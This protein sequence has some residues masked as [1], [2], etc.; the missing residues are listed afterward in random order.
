MSTDA[1]VIVIGAGPG[2]LSCA[3]YLA[4]VGKR[5]I[6]LDRHTVPGGNMSCFTHRDPATDD[7]YEFDVGLHYLGSCG[8]RGTMPSVLEPLG[9]RPDY[10]P[11]DQ[12]GYDTLLFESG[13]VEQFRVPAGLG[14][15]RDALATAFPTELEA[16]DAYVGL[17][18]DVRTVMSKASRVRNPKQAVDI[19]GPGYRTLRV[20]SAT[21]G[22]VFD[23]IGASPRLRT[24]L[25]GIGGTYA[26]APSKV[27]FLAHAGVFLHYAGGAWY[28]RGGGQ[29]IADALSRVITDNGGQVLLRTQ[30]D[31]ILLEGGAAVGVRV[32][33]PAADRRRGLSDTITA[34]IVVSNADL[35]RTFTE[36]LPA[37]AVP[38]KLRT[39]MRQATMAVPLHV[40]YVIL[41]R[42]LAAEGAP[43]TNWWVYPDDDLDRAYAQVAAGVMPRNAFAYLTSASLKDP[44]NERLA[45]PGQTNIQIMTA[46]PADH[47]FWGLHGG[48]P[49]AGESYRRNPEYLRRKQQLHDALMRSAE[50][51]IPGITESVVYSESATPITHERF[52]RS[53]GGTSY[54]LAATPDQMLLKRPAARTAIKGLWIVGASTRYMHGISGTL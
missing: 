5:V 51:A 27:S 47:R 1:D 49:V 54:G 18:R 53:T 44:G 36:L 39:R 20:M 35:K 22:D 37:E 43:N 48:G 52:V 15:Y 6:V 28:P 23:R 17:L 31:E 3:A 11:M 32:R 13:S 29:P 26:V 42:D 46:A 14:N 41:D 30:V 45:R 8:P 33:R 9:I 24:V 25:A 16:I 21:L 50:R 4:A 19:L 12:T 38:A 7:Q 10:L 40:E 2:G 34:P